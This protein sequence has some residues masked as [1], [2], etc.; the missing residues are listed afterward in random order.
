MVVVT[1]LNFARKAITYEA[2]YLVHVLAYGSVLAAIPHQFST[3]SDIAGKPGM[4]EVR[5]RHILVATEDQ[6]KKIIAEIKKGGDFAALARQHS[7][8]PGAQQSQY[9]VRSTIPSR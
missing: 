7:S 5:A 2:W 4:E 1:S 6:A 3:R 8:D 9:R